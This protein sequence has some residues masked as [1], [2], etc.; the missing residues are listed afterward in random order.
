MNSPMLL[1]SKCILPMLLRL[2]IVLG[3]FLMQM[4]E[5]VRKGI[6]C[7]EDILGAMLRLQSSCVHYR[8][9]ILSGLEKG[10]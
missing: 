7:R 3:R 8:E 2:V 10:D 4:M 1:L 5:S 9:C 6:G